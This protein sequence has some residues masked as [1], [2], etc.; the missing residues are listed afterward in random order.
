[1]I[2]LTKLQ[3]KQVESIEV[4]EGA[5]DSPIQYWVELKRGWCFED[6]GSHCFGEDT[7]QLVRESLTLV[8]PCTCTHH[9]AT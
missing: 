6:Q 1:M 8:R 5:F 2:R 9:C 7:Q 3:R 4:E